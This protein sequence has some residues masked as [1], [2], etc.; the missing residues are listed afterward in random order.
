[1]KS[2]LLPAV[3]SVENLAIFAFAQSGELLT[4][5]TGCGIISDC[6]SQ[7]GTATHHL[8]LCTTGITDPS[9]LNGSSYV[10]QKSGSGCS[11]FVASLANCAVTDNISCEP[12]SLAVSCEYID[13]CSLVQE[14]CSF[15]A[16]GVT[17]DGNFVPC[18]IEG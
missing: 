10:I 4:G 7:Q 16:S 2:Y 1:M 3:M 14:D 6:Q 18:P 9:V 5:L 8:N 12:G 17:T 13:S 15:D 11:D